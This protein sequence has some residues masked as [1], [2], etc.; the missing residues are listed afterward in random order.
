MKIKHYIQKKPVIVRTYNAKGNEKRIYLYRGFWER[1]LI[2]VKHYI[3]VTL[4]S[5]AIIGWAAFAG[6]IFVKETM[7]AEVKSMEKLVVVE[8]NELPPILEKIARCESNNRM[9]DSKGRL[10][11]NANKNGSTDIGK[12]MINNKAWEA[13]AVELGID[14][15]TESGNRE[16]AE[17]IFMNYGSEPWYSSRHCFAR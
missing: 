10:M 8:K 12:F 16:M 3:R 13:K 5:T 2:K 6:A 15:Y 1:T 9:R 17:Y 7:P 4:W 14:I 11:L